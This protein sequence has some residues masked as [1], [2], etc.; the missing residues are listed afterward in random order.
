[1]APDADIN[2]WRNALWSEYRRDICT[3]T[4]EW[5][6]EREHRL[7]NFTLLADT[8]PN[9]TRTLTYDFSALKGIIFGVNTTDYDKIA[10]IDLIKQKCKTAGRAEFDFRQ[11]FYSWRTGR[12]E[13]YPLNLEMT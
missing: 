6:F 4:K 5:E 12:I 10:I 11:A 13:S 9:E 2:A 7:V 3:K 1:M 8:L